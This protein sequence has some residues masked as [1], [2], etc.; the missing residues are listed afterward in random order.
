LKLFEVIKQ[1]KWD[2]VMQHLL[3]YC[4]SDVAVLFHKIYE[5]LYILSPTINTNE[6][7]HI[8]IDYIP[9]ENKHDIYGTKATDSFKYVLSLSTWEEW[10]GFSLSATL[11]KTM[12]LDEMVAH[13]M[14][15]M[16]YYG[17]TSEEV[18]KNRDLLMQVTKMSDKKIYTEEK[19]TCPFCDGKKVQDDMQPC[20]HCNAEGTIRVVYS[21]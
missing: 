17:T 10:L 7:I 18:K 15:E 6:E 13:C 3:L 12:S 5:K 21:S 8:A 4:D 14:W 16:T 20:S 11:L 2:N 9:G 19:M 1:T